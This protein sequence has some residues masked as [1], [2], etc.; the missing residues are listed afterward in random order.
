MTRAPE[1][2]GTARWRRPRAGAAAALYLAVSIALILTL[3]PF[4]WMAL[5]SLK[6]EVELSLSPPTFL[7][8]QPTLDNYSTWLTQLDFPLHLGNSLIVAVV[9]VA[10]NL[11][12]CTMFG[13]ALAKLDFPGKRMLF[14]LVM[15]TLMVPGIVTMI[16][17]FVIV[18]NL[19]LAD[20]YVALILPFIATPLGVFLMRQ[21]MLAIPDPLL[22]AARIDGAGEFRVLLRIVVPQ[23]GAP[24]ATLAILTFLSSWNNFLWPLVVAQSEELYTL[25]VALAL[26]AIGP[27]GIQYG[28][29]MAGTV[30]VV[31][32]VLVLF[33][34][35]QR[36]VIRGIA[37]TG[38]R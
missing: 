21:Y 28:L 27:N 20:T 15:G 16:P 37:T 38:I 14:L 6:T 23:C 18:A 30:L 33:V 11:V 31:A 10:G 25:P 13:Y 9:V 22:E 34:A 32:P 29:L 26:Y 3:L 24:L 4:A 17:L 36:F 5:G 19:G 7:P 2:A 12:F 8:L 1:T 35:L